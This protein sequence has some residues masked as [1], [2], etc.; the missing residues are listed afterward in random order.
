MGIYEILAYFFVYGTWMV[1]IGRICGS[2]S[3]EGLST[4]DS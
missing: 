4:E 1:K 2:K 3:K